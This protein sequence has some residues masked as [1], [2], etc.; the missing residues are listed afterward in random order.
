MNWT[1]TQS[2][3]RLSDYL[4]RL[5]T[6]E[7]TAAFQA[8]LAICP[9]CATLVSHVGG[10]V[11]MMRAMPA[12]EVPPRLFH[13]ILDATPAP[14]VAGWRRRLRPVAFLWHP[15]F[16]M[17][18][19]TV[20]ASFLIVFHAAA[21]PGASMGTILNPAN[22]AGM[23]N[24]QA[25]VTYAHAAKFVSEVQLI[26]EIESRLQPEPDQTLAPPEPAA[27]PQ[28]APQSQPNPAQPKQETKPRSGRRIAP[29]HGFYA[30]FDTFDTLDETAN[31]L[32]R[33]RS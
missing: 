3:E 15:Q 14:S 30:F 12:V 31:S 9:E 10:A 2:E 17:G 32:P 6:P 1:C 29:G 11:R 25:H 22:W 19:L 33:S 8:H 28:S 13:K 21:G 18:A 5:T 7:E 27:A 20:A 23:V 24:R 16:A 4:D 26:Y